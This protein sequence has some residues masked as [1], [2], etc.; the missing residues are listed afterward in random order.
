VAVDTFLG[1]GP[2][3]WQW[4]LLLALVIVALVRH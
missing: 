2:E 4:I 1:Q 3:A